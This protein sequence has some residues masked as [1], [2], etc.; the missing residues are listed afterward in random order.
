MI[1]EQVR[2]ETNTAI[3]ERLVENSRERTLMEEAGRL[4][5]AAERQSLLDVNA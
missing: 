4:L 1:L 5:V 3:I 2:E